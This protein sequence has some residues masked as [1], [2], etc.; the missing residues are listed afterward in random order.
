MIMVW[1]PPLILSGASFL[2]L[3]GFFAFTSMA[4]VLFSAGGRQQL[5]HDNRIAGTALDYILEN[6]HR[7]GF[8][9]QLVRKFSAVGAA[10]SAGYWWVIFS[11]TAVA[12]IS[13]G[14][15][16][17]SVVVVMI[18]VEVIADIIP[19][20]AA[21]KFP[22]WLSQT[23]ATPVYWMGMVL[24]PLYWVSHGLT[25]KICAMAGVSPLEARKMMTEDE[26]KQLV[27]HAQQEGIL[28]KTEQEMIRSIFHFSETVVREIMTPRMDT[29]CIE[30]NKTVRDVITLIT[31]QGHSRIPV[32]EDSVDTIVGFVYAKDL[33][34]VAE[35]SRNA[36]LKK[37]MRPA[38]FIPETQ[39]IE[40]VLHQLKKGKTHLGIVIDEFGSM[41]GLVTLEDIIEEI[42]G[43]IQDEYDDDVLPELTEIAP[44]RFS[45]TATMN[46]TDFSEQ[47]GISIPESD[48][49]DTVGGFV[50]H[51]SGKL[52]QRGECIEYLGHEFHVMDMTNRRINRL[53]FRQKGVSK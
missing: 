9:I 34:S 42:V 6:P 10:I 51:H 53:E 23:I 21:T 19:K 20:V 41:A 4:E 35:S 32:F 7:I 50:L 47:I 40:M 3:L 52:P 31:D 25:A 8:A 39:S 17:I 2:V 24:L 28:E 18:L 49:Y 33:L 37:F 36:S 13:V 12:R 44:G 30:S 11:G 48:D 26:I 46:M 1:F 22:L 15:A 14:D 5:R 43:D 29:V 45:V 38:V 16:V 27:D